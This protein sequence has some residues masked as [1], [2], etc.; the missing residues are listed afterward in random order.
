MPTST[1]DHIK[2]LTPNDIAIA[3]QEIDALPI[4]AASKRALKEIVLA[5]NNA[6]AT[7]LE[8]IIKTLPK[9]RQAQIWQI[10]EEIA[11]RQQAQADEAA[12]NL[13]LLGL[14]TLGGL[15]A[16]YLAADTQE[17]IQAAQ[18]L[19]IMKRAYVQGIQDEIDYVGCN[20]RAR[21][22]S[23]AEL[24][25]LQD[26]ATADAQSIIATWNTDATKELSK[27]Y[28]ENPSA[29]KQFFLE[30]MKAW[31]EGRILQKSLFIAFNTETRAR[32]YGRMLFMQRNYAET[33]KFIFR[34]PPP[35]CPDCMELRGMGAVDFAFIEQYPNPQHPNCE[36]Y[37]G[38]LR[39]P[40]IDCAS[41]WLG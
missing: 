29:S 26:M 11:A 25:H 14:L 3:L 30:N 36:H 15:I 21:Y 20:A 16:A 35:I 4:D 39:K 40:R 1:L 19:E 38:V 23:G 27:L 34:G 18:L 33:T 24:Q 32:E 8:T 2:R 31:A 22:P 12:R 9:V 17:A 13:L 5:L 10:F 41:L 28:E 7:K 37:W 6:D